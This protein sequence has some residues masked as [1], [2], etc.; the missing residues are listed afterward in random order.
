MSDKKPAQP[1]A[2]YIEK[3]IH[4]TGTPPTPRVPVKIQ[5]KTPP[6]KDK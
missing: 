3:K 2:K 6:T 1:Q 5:P 4:G